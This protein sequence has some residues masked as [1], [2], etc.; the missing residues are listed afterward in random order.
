R[1]PDQVGVAVDRSGRIGLERFDLRPR[2]SQ[3]VAELSQPDVDRLI[4][5][6]VAG[7]RDGVDCVVDLGIVGGEVPGGIRTIRTPPGA[8]IPRGRGVEYLVEWVVVA[9]VRRGVIRYVGILEAVLRVGLAYRVA[10]VRGLVR[11]GAVVE[12]R[13]QGI[14]RGGA[15]S[16]AECL[17]VPG[18]VA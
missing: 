3:Q 13:W 12:Y 6:G 15:W 18:E 10:Q 9:G 11:A 1:P 4:E 16:G 7:V 2:A 14:G 17:D 8:E 5:S